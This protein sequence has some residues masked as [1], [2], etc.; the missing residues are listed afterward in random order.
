MLALQANQ[1]IALPSGNVVRLVRIDEDGD[2]VC[3][4]LPGCK[5]RGEVAFAAGWLSRLW[6]QQT[7]PS[8]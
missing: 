3:E 1:Q 6:C 8:T 7:A 2:W 5:A 4:Y